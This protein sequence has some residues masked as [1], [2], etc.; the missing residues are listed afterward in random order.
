M[1]REHGT[2]YFIGAGPGDPELITV[3]G[4]RLI[5]EA[6]L[7]L[8]AGSLVPA[9][10]VACAKATAQVVDSSSMTLEE[11]HAAMR[12]AAFAGLQVAR[13]HTGDPSLYGAV[14]E[15]AALLERDGIPYAIIPGVT[16][17]FAAA[18]AAKIS[19]T[20][21]ETAQSFAITRMEGRT[22]VPPGQRVRDMAAHGGS[23]AVYLSAPETERLQAELLEAGLLP[24]TVVIAAYRVGWPEE[25]I[26]RTTVKELAAA[27]NANGLD[28]QTVFLILPGESRLSGGSADTRSRLYAGEFAHMFRDRDRSR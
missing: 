23:L 22:P 4:R 18:A 20:V 14:R 7:V 11:T 17:A 6:A 28:R 16:A 5:E 3:K 2:V 1:N 26:I 8:Y 19:F 25:K 10:L 27:V 12:E 9:A 21:P 15:Q 24:D 13:V